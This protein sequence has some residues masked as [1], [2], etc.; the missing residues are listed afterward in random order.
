MLLFLALLLSM[1]Y[2][3]YARLD[4]LLSM[5]PQHHASYTDILDL[6][7]APNIGMSHFARPRTRLLFS[8]VP[9]TGGTSI[10]ESASEAGILWGYQLMKQ[11]TWQPYRIHVKCEK[12]G[13]CEREED[14]DLFQVPLWHVPL[15]WSI[16]ALRSYNHSTVYSDYFNLDQVDYFCVV[17]HPF[18]KMISEYRYLIRFMKTAFAKEF[19][20]VLSKRE[21]HKLLQQQCTADSLN[22]WIRKMLTFYAK[23]RVAKNGALCWMGCHFVA[24]HEFV[25]G[26]NGELLCRHV[27]RFEHLSHD[28][29]Q[30][31]QR[32]NLLEIQRNFNNRPPNKLSALCQHSN[33]SVEH[34][35]D[36][37]KQLVYDFYR[38]DFQVFNYSR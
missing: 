17:R 34:L 3:L 30:L 6:E 8:H 22:Y 5:Q 2:M 1:L 37:T 12:F 23:D 29:T 26:D 33:F 31:M 32:Y 18:T 19:A 35:H 4:S 36:D 16:E 27:L 10:E 9:K 28:F 7:T 21:Q 38:R 13:I 25:Y 20:E 14:E 11:D 15:K 24:Q